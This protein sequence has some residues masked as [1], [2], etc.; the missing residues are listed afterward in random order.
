MNI[1]EKSYWLQKSSPTFSTLTKDI[2]TDVAIVGGGITGLTTAYLLAKQGVQ[3]ALFEADRLANGTTGHTTGKITAQHGL[4]YDEL[5]RHFG[6]ERARQYYDAQIDA[7]KWLKQT[8]QT[9]DISCDFSEEDA[10]VYTND[11]TQMKKIEKE[12][13]AYQALNISGS[14]VNRLP[15]DLPMKMAI[16]MNNQAQFHPLK[17]VHAIVKA[18]S[19]YEHVEI[20]EKTCLNNIKQTTSN[21]PILK[22]TQGHAVTAKHVVLT[23]H[24][25]FYDKLGF[26]FS[27]MYAERSHLIAVSTRR[28]SYP[29]GMYI[30]AENPIR[31]I[32]ATRE[33]DQDILLFG[34]E[35][36]RTGDT[37]HKKDPFKELIGFANQQFSIE[38]VLY[39]WATQDLTTTD[40]IPYIGRLSMKTPAIYVATG[41][42]KWGLTNGTIAAHILTD[43]ILQK[44][45]PYASLFSPQRFHPNPDLKKLLTINAAAMKHLVKGKISTT[46]DTLSKL[47]ENEAIKVSIDKNKIGIYRDENKTMHT[48]DTTC[49]HLGC[50]VNWNATEK[51]WDC[52]CH[53]SR[54]SIHGEVLEG[55]ANSPLSTYTISLEEHT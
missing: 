41:Y 28:Q 16:Q 25:P 38:K 30:T 22:S 46:E 2:T 39:Q 15:L 33:A 11:E 24:F 55:P 37:K 44:D 51:T 14:I 54:F 26:Y 47:D 8:I 45:N 34:G 42:R 9:Y 50:E 31:S 1:D 10:Y 53:G 48:V 17:Y 40:K 3:V 36:H 52:P 18:L 19:Q 20:W 7:I 43:S 21:Q 32:R 35:G 12:A 29:G 23:S 5:I 49:T 4:I 27:R 13:A 6:L